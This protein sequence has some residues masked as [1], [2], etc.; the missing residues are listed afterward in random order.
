M[1]RYL[2]YTAEEKQFLEDRNVKLG[3]ASVCQQCYKCV[4]TCPKNVEIPKL[5]RS[6]TYA[7]CYKNF[8]QARAVLNEIPEERGLDVCNVCNRCI[9]NCVYH[10]DIAKRI[11]ELKTMKLV[12]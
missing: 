6:H 10:V 8:D 3:M 5:I 9:A 4:L 7:T 2:N 11:D 12:S 1:A